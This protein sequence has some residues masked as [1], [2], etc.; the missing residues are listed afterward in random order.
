MH[1][2]E[3][4]KKRKKENPFF[5]EKFSYTDIYT[6]NFVVRQIYKK[7]KISVNMSD[8]TPALTIKK[9]LQKKKFSGQYN[10]KQ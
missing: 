6:H 9:K 2:Y 5:A 3:T 8:Q 7:K 1:D 4:I 10:Q